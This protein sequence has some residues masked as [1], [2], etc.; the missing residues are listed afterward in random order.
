[1]K[2]CI[3]KITNTV[4]NKCYIGSAK[5]IVYR[6]RRH[7]QLL[8][9]NMYHS[10]LLQR[11]WNKHKSDSFK[12]NIIENVEDVKQL[13]PKEQY[14]LDLLHPDYNICKIT[15]KGGKLGIKIQKKK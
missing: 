14:Y 2:S 3:Y 4:D 8:R 5:N 9:K 11:A 1:M 6:W 15:G 12:F 13:V 10:I 7:K